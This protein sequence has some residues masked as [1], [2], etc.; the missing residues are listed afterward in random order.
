[1]D[2]NVYYQPPIQS[3]GNMP[4]VQQ[5]I[6]MFQTPPPPMPNGAPVPPPYMPAPVTVKKKEHKPLSKKDNIFVFIFL[7]TA[8]L[9]VDF[10]LFHGFALGFTIS[11]F[12]L[13]GVSTAY[14]WDREGKPDLFSLCCG[15]IS[16]AGSVTFSLYSN[17]FI[18]TIMFI[19]IAGLFTLYCLGISRSYSKSRGN[20]KMLIDLFYASV[21]ETFENIGDI[22]GSLKSEADRSKRNMSALIG[23]LIA[24][25]VLAV[26]IPL[27]ISSDAAFEKLVGV[28]AKNI[29]KYL[30]E[31]A[32]AIVLT[33]FLFSYMFGKKN[34][35]NVQSRK[36]VGNFK[37][38][39]PVS[40]SVAFLSVISFTY[41]VYLFSQLAYFFSAFSGLLPEGY[42]RGAS[43]FARRGFYEMFAICAINVVMI[44][45]I[46]MV[47]KRK[48]GKVSTGIKVLSLFISLFSVLMI[49]TAIQ[50]MKLN[51]TTYGFTRNRL[52]IFVFMLMILVVIIFFI[53]HIFAPKVPYMQPIIIICS[54]MFV[55]LSFANIDA[56]TYEH[57]VKA[58]EN[59]TL[60]KL[61]MYTISTLNNSDMYFAK[62]AQ[63]EDKDIAHK[64]QVWLIRE[65]FVYDSSNYVIKDNEM[66]LREP[67]DF[68]SYC[69]DN[70]K[71]N[72]TVID[73]YNSLDTYDRLSF[74]LTQ[75][76]LEDGYYDYDKDIIEDYNGNHAYNADTGRY[77]EVKD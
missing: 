47:T 72:K 18:N 49:I 14:L 38:K 48:Q 10:A 39:V 51:I 52:L 23:V 36:N 50:K 24:V 54:A 16:L 21:I 41:L 57:N 5:D 12:I 59:G 66:K 58:Y 60:K 32:I 28:I 40:G 1:M 37:K 56:F 30:L 17:D 11:Y 31:L 62:L 43:A 63:S 2:K 45:I 44:S 75:H 19:L 42:T 68:R 26:I 35:L 69:R 76:L 6:N 64:A 9:F 3:G 15:A 74:D 73:Y 27:L 20:F 4:P 55:A 67:S 71:A 34:K 29:G 61:D 8:F 77:E 33:P 46:S 7:A 70:E 13:F 65:Y 25:P 22:I 53:I